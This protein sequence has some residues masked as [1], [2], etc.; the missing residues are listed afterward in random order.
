MTG[1]DPEIGQRKTARKVKEAEETSAGLTIADRLTRQASN[2]TVNLPYVDE[3]G[4]Y[5]IVLKVPTRKEYDKI[6]S[7]QADVQI[8]GKQDEASDELYH[9]LDDLTVDPSL[10]Y[11]YWKDGD[12]GMNALVDILAKLLTTLV[13]RVQE[14]QT[15]REN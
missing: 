12:Y 13:D 4:E 7:L 11:A 2:Q 10:N 15:F 1:D 6:L 9:I 8:A 14:V 3:D 5:A